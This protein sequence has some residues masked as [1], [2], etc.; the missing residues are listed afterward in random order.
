M[1]RPLS[2]AQAVISANSA[3]RYGAFVAD[4][5]FPEVAVALFS[6]TYVASLTF[7]FSYYVGNPFEPR[8]A[9]VELYALLLCDKLDKVGSNNGLDNVIITS[10]VAKF[11]AA[12]DGVVGQQHADLVAVD[13]MHLAIL[14]S[15]GYANAVS[16]GV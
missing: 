10:E 16:V 4:E 12:D 7:V 15:N 13:E 8:I 11:F 14:S 1:L 3:S 6:S 5:V 9:V 2:R